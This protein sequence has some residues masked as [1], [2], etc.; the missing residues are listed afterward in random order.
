MAARQVFHRLTS[1][2]PAA[3]IALGLTGCILRGS[4]T[5]MTDTRE[6][7]AFDSIEVG[8]AFELIVHVDPAAAQRVEVSGD[9]NIV[10]EVTTS[11]SGGELEIAIDH[12]MVRPKLDM[13]VEVW[14]AS[15]AGLEA[16]GAS[17]I[18]VEGLHGEA[19][20]IEL[21][22]ASDSRFSGAVDR[23]EIELSGASDLDARELH[24]KIVDLELSGAGDAEV[25]ASER[26]DAEV[27]GAGNVRY[28]GS[29]KEVQQDVSGAGSITPGP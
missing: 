15:L 4:G 12:G 19:F 16:S 18:T 24:A 17:D 5:A 29:P 11:V 6:V 27:S 8:G 23:F 22:G 26:L 2:T 28:F 1:T 9:D 7:A 10:P 21:S 3:L 14:V 13:K 20:E 25:W